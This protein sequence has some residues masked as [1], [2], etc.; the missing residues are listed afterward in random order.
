[1]IK[2]IEDLTL[3]EI[4]EIDF[5]EKE[6][7]EKLSFGELCVYQEVLNKIKARYDELN[8]QE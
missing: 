2:K 8:T 6:E 3:E 5:L 1:M 4:N 7:L